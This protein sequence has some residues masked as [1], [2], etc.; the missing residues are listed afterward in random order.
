MPVNTDRFG[1][2][3]SSKAVFRRIVTVVRAAAVFLIVHAFS[4][5]AISTDNLVTDRCN[6]HSTPEFVVA[7]NPDSPKLHVP[8]TNQQTS[9]KH[10][11]SSPFAWA[12]NSVENNWVYVVV[13]HSATESG[14]VESIHAEHQ[15]RKD[16]SGN[17]WLG[18]G[19]HFVIGNGAG[20]A[21]GQ[22]QPTFR[23][24]QQMHGAHSGS[25]VHNSNGIGVCLIG[26]FQSD[27]PTHKQMKA[28]TTLVKDLSQRYN[29]P[30]R[31]VIGHNT[32]KPTSC[33]GKNFP[34]QDVRNSVS[35]EI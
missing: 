20:M 2:T 19:Y 10:K 17:S 15:Q 22:V 4:P 18:I 6:C 26:N 9:V 33:P 32:V 23:W 24:Q 14:S 1:K 12:P 13:H 28:V 21:D 29:I 7:F 16:S 35:E 11:G 30:A 25:V 27:A 8:F 31:L 34:L 3:S 5:A